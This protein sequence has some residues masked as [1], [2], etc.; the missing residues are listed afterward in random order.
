MS[1]PR[2]WCSCH[3]PALLPSTGVEMLS[4][5]LLTIVTKHIDFSS[6][7]FRPSQWSMVSQFPCTSSF[8]SS[9]NCKR[10]L[11]TVHFMDSPS[12]IP[13]PHRPP[14]SDSDI[15]SKLKLLRSSEQRGRGKN[16]YYES[17][18]YLIHMRRH[19]EIK[20]R[21]AVGTDST[22]KHYGMY[23]VKNEVVRWNYGNYLRHRFYKHET[24]QKG[25][26]LFSISLRLSKKWV[27]F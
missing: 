15:M 1:L 17:T 25:S 20:L 16:N 27:G 23:D 3:P 6:S 21:P 7:P 18:A 11:N 5:H 2:L 13:P 26:C 4:T 22:P 8:P 9:L 10:Q 14:A 19:G 12:S 24:N